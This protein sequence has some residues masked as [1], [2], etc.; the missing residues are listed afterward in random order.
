V[1]DLLTLDKLPVADLYALPDFLVDEIR[2]VMSA[3]N[4]SQTAKAT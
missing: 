1:I 2:D 4:R 3:W